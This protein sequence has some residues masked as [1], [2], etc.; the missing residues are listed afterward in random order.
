METTKPMTESEFIE[1]WEKITAR[2][3]K[4]IRKEKN[5]RGYK[6]YRKT[7]HSGLWGER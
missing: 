6:Y 1:R 7:S 3:R 2:L 4:A 5:N